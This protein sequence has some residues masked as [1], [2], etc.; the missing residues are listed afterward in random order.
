MRSSTRRTEWSAGLLQHQPRP[1]PGRARC[2]CRR[3]GPLT[4]AQMPQRRLARLLV[5]QPGE[6]VEVGRRCPG[7]PSGAGPGSARRTSAGCRPRRRRRRRRSRRSPTGRPRA[8]VPSAAP[9]GLQHVEPLDDEDV[10]P[11]DGL[12]L[13]GHDVV[14]LV[15]V[16]RRDDLLARRTSRRPGSAAAP[17]GRSSR[18]SPCGPAGRAPRAPRS[19][20]RKPSVVTRSTRGV[21]GPAAEQRS[22]AGGRW[23]SCRRRRCRRRAMTNGTFAV[24]VAEELALR[25][26][27]PAARRDV[28][29]EQLGQR[30]VDRG[31]LVE[32]DP[33]AERGQ[34]AQLR[35]VQRQPGAR[36]P[37]PATR[38][39]RTPRRARPSCAFPTSRRHRAVRSGSGVRAGHPPGWGGRRS[40][41]EDAARGRPR[42]GFC[43]VPTRP[44]LLD[45]IERY[46]AAAPLPD[47]RIETAGALDVP[48][49]DPAWPYPARPRP[50][51]GP[52]T[53]DD[54]RAAVA[55]Q[56]PPACRAAVEWVPERSP[57]TAAAARAAGLDRGGAAAARGR[58]PGRA[59]C[60]RPASGSTSSGADDPAARRATSG[61]PRPPSP[62]PAAPRDVPEVARGHLGRGRAPARRR[63]ASGSRP[64]AP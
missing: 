40:G 49:G 12:P 30:Q 52:V 64:A 29:V 27:K 36:P 60:C 20:S 42:L 56:E 59:G 28:Q 15:V 7:T 18:G 39:G 22:A 26:P 21:P 31:D 13:A 25:R 61:W 3:F 14:G 45:C 37:G 48:I 51:A 41:R 46:F 34:L 55:L 24:R 47:A 1:R 33:V 8:A 17:A 32:V 4:A 54:V 23:C 2:C 63:C 57:E 11:V 6:A 58:R 50:D 35:L 62:T 38:R 10:R 43:A 19:G 9:A 5:G 44:G 53:A 16:D